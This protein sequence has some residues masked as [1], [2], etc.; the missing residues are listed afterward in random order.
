MPGL[1]E[2]RAYPCRPFA[3]AGSYCAGYRCRNEA[4]CFVA[5]QASKECLGKMVHVPPPH[6]HTHPLISLLCLFLLV[7]EEKTLPMH[8]ELPASSSSWGVGNPPRQVILC[9]QV[10]SGMGRARRPCPWLSAPGGFCCACG[11]WRWCRSPFGFLRALAFWGRRTA[12]TFVLPRSTGWGPGSCW[13]WPA[14][15]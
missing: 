12:Q 14:A 13:C 15:G 11:R 3:Q 2:E 9:R 4:P 8:Q 6:T 10:R 5:A 7:Q 1:A